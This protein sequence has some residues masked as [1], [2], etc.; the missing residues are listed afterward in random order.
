MTLGLR[1]RMLIASAMLALTVAASLAALLYQVDAQRGAAERSRHSQEVLA[2]ASELEKLVLDMETGQRGFLL[3]GRDEFLGPYLEARPRFAAQAARLEKLVADNPEQEAIARSIET[4]LRSYARD[5]VAPQVAL[6]RQDRSGAMRNASGGEGKR[7]VDAI[8]ETFSRFITN[9]RAL[10][11]ARDRRSASEEARAFAVGLGGLALSVALVLLFALYLSRLVVEPVR[12]VAVAATN[13]AR[14]NLSARVAAGGAA[15]VAELGRAFNQ[16]ASSIESGRAEL[17]EANVELETQNSELELQTVELEDQQAQL[18]YAN[19][20]LAAQQ[21]ELEHALE[22]VAEEKERLAASAGFA[23]LIAARTAV[24]DLAGVTLGAIADAVTADVGTVYVSGALDERAFTLAAVRGVDVERLPQELVPGAGLPGRALA[25]TRTVRADHGEA[26]LTVPAFGDELRVSHELHVPLS[27][28]GRVL[29]VLTLA[30]VGDRPFAES[31]LELVEHFAHQAATGLSNAVA[32]RSARELA[33]I[34]AAVLDATVDAIRMVDLEGRTV[35][36]NR[37]M[38]AMSGSIFGFEE[39]GS[40]WE[41]TGGIADRTQ[42]PDEYRKKMELLR[43]DPHLESVDVY[44]V[45]DTGTWVQRYSSPV[46]NAEGEA[47]GRIFVLRD[48]TAEREADQQKEEILA[49]VSHELRT[50]LASILGFSELL[51]T[52]TPDEEQT[53]RFAATIHRESLR[54]TSLI[55]DFLDLQRIAEGGLRVDLRRFD[56]VPLLHEQADVYA[57]QSDRHLVELDVPD[58]PLEA[59]GDRA[60]IGQVVANLLSNAIKYSPEGGTVTLSASNS[61]GGIRIAVR[62]EGIGIPHEQQAKL[63]TKFFRVDSSDTR[64]IG[65]TGLGLALAREIVEAHGGRVGVESAPGS[66]STFWLELQAA[67]DDGANG[68]ALV[69]EDDPAAIELLR[70]LLAAEGLGTAV[71]TN[72]AD[73]LELA[74]RETPALICLDIELGGGL[75]G[76]QVLERLKSLPATAAIPVVVCAAGNGRANAAALGASDFVSKPFTAARLRAA[77]SRVLPA[78]GAAT[79]LVVDDDVSIRTMIV[80]RL[81]A[82]GHDVEVA[83]DGVEALER[84]ATLRPDAVV[85]DLSMPR[86]DGFGVLERMRTDSSTRSIPVVV[87]TAQRLAPAERRKLLERAVSVLAKPEG[88]GEQLQETLRRA[89]A[90]R[91]TNAA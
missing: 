17:A 40:I 59:S 69:I 9:E 75:D 63:F 91:R 46:R 15:E 57:A 19:A 66:G 44:R 86:L 20:E 11:D 24:D 26:G 36:M 51:V 42:D 54:L 65:G 32:L 72:G 83:R 5:W 73:G 37:A 14:G 60:R 33:S 16:M 79:I 61:P 81:T 53:E 13:L 41:M 6:A 82:D 21:H 76:W 67:V 78:E 22:E 23:T 10:A 27:A 55:D 77:V 84:I 56:L 45:A 2:T 29:G 74:A 38:A 71:A 31:E 64:T 80:E 1:R 48:I 28:A 47:I 25:E 35:L 12:R 90:D 89:L 88:A 87:L 8:R 49:T 52:R 39:G 34:N 62:D 68:R 4:Q 3:T 50:P 7:R 30:R 70:E 85:L 58:G 18:E 43:A